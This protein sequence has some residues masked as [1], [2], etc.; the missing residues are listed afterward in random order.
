VIDG[1]GRET[2]EERQSDG[3]KEIGPEAAG[4]HDDSL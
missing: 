1:M 4:E 2:D 3:D